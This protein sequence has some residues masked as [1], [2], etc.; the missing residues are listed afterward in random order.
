MTFER[1]Q[2][3]WEQLAAALEQVPNRP[4]TV[5]QIATTSEDIEQRSDWSDIRGR[6]VSLSHRYGF[7]YPSLIGVH[8]LGTKGGPPQILPSRSSAKQ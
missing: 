3:T 1:Q 6:L 8:P 4:Q 5:F 2:V 7:E